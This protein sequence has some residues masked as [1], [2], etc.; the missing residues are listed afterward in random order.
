MYKNCNLSRDQ[1]I[2]IVEQYVTNVF[3]NITNDIV[4]CSDDLCD[5]LAALE[6]VTHTFTVSDGTLTDT[7]SN[8]DTLT[9]L[10]DAD[11]LISITKTG[12]DEFTVSIDTTGATLGD[13]P[14][15]DGADVVWT[16]ISGTINIDNTAIVSENGDDSTGI[17]GRWDQPYASIAGAFA[18]MSGGE[19]ILIMPGNYTEG[20]LTFG[21]TT[22]DIRAIGRV[23]LSADITS[24]GHLSIVGEGL[25]F[26]G[27]SGAIGLNWNDGTGTKRLVID[28]H[29][30]SGT[31]DDRTIQL[32]GGLDAVI[33]A[34]YLYNLNTAV[35]PATNNII[36]QS[37]GLANLTVKCDFAF[38][39]RAV[40]YAF[41]FNNV[42]NSNS[43]RAFLDIGD[44]TATTTGK[45]LY[46]ED[47]TGTVK[48]SARD[49][50]NEPI[51]F[52]NSNI[53]ATLK[54][55]SD[56]TP[57]DDGSDGMVLVTGES[58]NTSVIKFT[59]CVI[60]G[61]NSD[62][63]LE[64]DRTGVVILGSNPGN[65][66]TGEDYVDAFFDSCIITN[67]SAE[68]EAQSVSYGGNTCGVNSNIRSWYLGTHL[69]SGGSQVIFADGTRCG[70]SISANLAEINNL[71]GNTGDQTLTTTNFNYL[72]AA[73]SSASFSVFNLWG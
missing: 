10:G 45:A 64:T 34:V 49:L 54:V 71:G 56:A 63:A 36:L 53:E 65:T 42:G 60:T 11:K 14:T 25:T 31:S 72:G 8:G 15:F 24:S 66:A 23:T 21:S 46:C 1:V 39:G 67:T 41:S 29:T 32:T 52:K 17:I 68:T 62:N 19:T 59:N 51:Y 12:T 22:V 44:F 58:G 3:N 7:I 18:D 2:E 61:D 40:D 27:T 13:I 47:Y 48:F 20:S 69:S 57:D 30:F 9:L 26:N 38:V 37:G 28:V 50:A 73:W 4:P 33:K 70:G 55:Y 35:A 6:A 5:R 16:P 43:G